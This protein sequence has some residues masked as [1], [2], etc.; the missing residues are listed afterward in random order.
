MHQAQ[1]Q[2]NQK[3]QDIRRL[4]TGITQAEGDYRIL[5]LA[6][7]NEKNE[8]RHWFYSYKDKHRRVGTLLREKF[9]TQLLLRNY[10]HRLQQSQNY[11]RA[12]RQEL[13][14]CRDD[15]LLSDIQL[16]T[17]WGMVGYGPPIYRGNPGE[18]PEDFLRDFQRY[19]VASRMNVAP[20]AGGVAGRAEA[21]GL[22]ESCLEGPA[23]NWFLT[24]IKGKNWKCNNISDNLGVATITEIRTLA[25]GN[26]GNQIGGLNTAGEFHN[27]AGAEIGRIAEADGLFESCLEGPALNWYETNI[28]GKNWKCNNISDNLGV[29]TITAIRTLGAGNGG[30]QIGGLNTAGEFRNEASAE[31][32]RIGAGIATGANLIPNGTWNEDWS[33]AGGMPVN[34]APV[35][36]NGGGG[37][38][39]VTIAPVEAQKQMAIFGQLMQGSMQVEEFS[40]K[41]KKLGKL[42][43]MSPQQQR[44]QFI[45]GLSPMNQYNLR[46]MAKF[47]D[48]Q[49]NITTALAEAEKYTLAQESTPSS[50]PVFPTPNSREKNKHLS[51]MAMTRNEVENLI[52]SRMTPVNPSKSQEVQTNDN[53]VSRDDFKKLYDIVLGLKETMAGAKRTLSKKP[54]PGKQKADEIAMNKFLDEA[55]D[56]TSLPG[57][58]YDYDPIEDLRLQFEQLGINQAKMA[59]I[60]HA[61]LKSSQYKCSKCGKAG[62]N[63]RNCSKKKSKSR[64][65]NKSISKKKVKQKGKSSSKKIPKSRKTKQKGVATSSKAQNKSTTLEENIR[66]IMLDMLEKVLLPHQLEKLKPEN[67]NLAIPDFQKGKSSSKKIPKSRKTKQKGVATSIRETKT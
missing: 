65:S 47:H 13:D 3:N 6:Y 54:G 50:F 20:G 42:A 26:G 23:L 56:N 25:A 37:F 29:A 66:R 67:K 34:D 58:D 40:N 62:H 8:R 60:I 33:I 64:R 61:V 2:V 35:A 30:N 57:E 27:E 48:S 4:N 15:L 63:S 52:N 36:P 18:D 49:D 43:G 38:P 21:D 28:K 22:F 31:I 44:E 14:T 24:N 5:L 12:L 32:G 16:D 41:I 55:I 11:A 59:R 10:S 1:V 39:N 45:R 53:S 51:N 7:H 9:A 19:V 17:K 46:M